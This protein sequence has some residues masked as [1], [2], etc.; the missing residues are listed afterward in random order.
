MWGILFSVP[1]IQGIPISNLLVHGYVISLV[2][3]ILYIICLGSGRNC[4]YS[5]AGPPSGGWC[6]ISSHLAPAKVSSSLYSFVVPQ[7]E[8]QDIRYNIARTLYNTDANFL[9]DPA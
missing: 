8:E 3:C 7:T 6:T 1:T 9:H 2:P 5:S 4:S